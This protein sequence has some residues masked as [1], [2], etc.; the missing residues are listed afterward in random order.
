MRTDLVHVEKWL[1]DIRNR[2]LF[3]N[4]N[5]LTINCGETGSG[6]SYSALSQADIISPRGFRMKNLVFTPLQFLERIKDSDDF[7]KGDVIIFDEAGVG[8]SSREWYSIQ[9]K[10]LGN[11]LQTFRHMN[12]GVIFT[13]PNISFIDIQARRLFHNYIETI[14][15]DFRSETCFVKVFNIEHNSRFNKTYFKHP[16]VEGKAL[17][18]VG[19]PKPNPVLI[20]EYEKLK[21]E[22]S[23]KLRDDAHKELMKTLY[24]EEYK[25][26]RHDVSEIIEQ[27]KNNVDRYKKLWH[28]KVLI[29]DKL[30]E[31][32]FDIGSR[33][34]LKIKRA[35]EVEL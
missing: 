23:R 21:D 8:M 29:D 27:V 28:G 5:W 22:Y 25:T 10:L 34:S 17:R 6:K 35:L 26:N 31:T 7:K 20:E 11:I 4:K 13:T 24:P 15:I 33:K 1:S 12:V 2:M 18:Y 19:V 9:N 30:I 14:N 16:R 3:N 32:D